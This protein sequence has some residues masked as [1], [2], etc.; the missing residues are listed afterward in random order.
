MKG[1]LFSGDSVAS[2]ARGA[3]DCDPARTPPYGPNYEQ[4]QSMDGM[5]NR[6]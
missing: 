5:H 6:K 2:R 4:R 3:V 1:A